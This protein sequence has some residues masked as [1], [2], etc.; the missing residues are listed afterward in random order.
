M[1]AWIVSKEHIDALVSAA[2]V[3]AQENGSSFRWYDADDNHSHELTYTDTVRAN[4]VGRMLW[5]ENLASINAR[6]IDTIDHPENCPGPNDF[7]GIETVGDY[8]FKRT[9]RIPPVAILKAIS[10][11]EYQSCEHEEWKTSQA[12]E[13]CATLRDHVINLLPGYDE[14]PWGL[15]ADDIKELAAWA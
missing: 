10:C 11:Y 7:N 4:Q 15:D 1:S 9:P 13:F 12:H 14:A 8:V 2:L 5:A 3:C 6:Y